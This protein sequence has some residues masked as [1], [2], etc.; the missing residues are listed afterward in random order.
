M[1]PAIIGA[2][3]SLIGGLLGKSSADDAREQSQ[4]NL[5]RQIQLQREFAQHGIRWK[6]DDAKA[7]GIHPLYALG[8]QTTS[9]SPIS[10]TNPVDNSMANAV[11]HM[12][13]DVS[14]AVHQTRT[15]SEKDQAYID[16][17][18]GLQLEK[19]K[20]DVEIARAELASRTARIH[21]GTTASMPSLTGNMI[22]G[23]GNSPVNT[24]GLIS[25]HYN[26]LSGAPSEIKPMPDVGYADTTKGQYPVPAKDVKERIEDN[27]PHEIMHFVR[28][29]ILPIFGANMNPPGPAKPGFYWDYHP[30][31]GYRQLSIKE[32]TRNLNDLGK[33]LPWARKPHTYRGPQG[34]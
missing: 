4:Q 15:P 26:S 23:Q 30:M 22:P 11:S 16:A 3:G 27:L 31:Y 5:D 28:N 25:Q 9:F 24:T 34:Y 1:W 17:A 19:G 13:Q 10:L 18:R 29:N 21:Q 7:A 20:L 32:N 33:I 2:A 12:G 6:V 14:R 8:A